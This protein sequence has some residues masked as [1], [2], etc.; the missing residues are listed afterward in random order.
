MSV[1]KAL[2][3]AQLDAPKRRL[4]PAIGAEPVNK[5]R[6][7]L[8][9]WRCGLIPQSR[10]GCANIGKGFKHIAGLERLLLNHGLSTT[11]G[12]HQLDDAA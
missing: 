6:N 1:A 7:A 5:I 2:P 10:S 9:N 12:F 8:I 4:Q 3:T 11:G